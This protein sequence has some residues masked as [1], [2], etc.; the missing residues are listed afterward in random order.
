M[1]Q[2]G[3]I[4]PFA[5]W[6]AVNMPAQVQN[7]VYNPDRL[8]KLAIA[9]KSRDSFAE[10]I[11]ADAY[12][13]PDWILERSHAVLG[14]DEDGNLEVLYLAGAPFEDINR[15]FAGGFGNTMENV[16]ADV[17]PILRAPF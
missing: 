9:T 17:T 1:R 10:D 16:L 14:K 7:L 12:T 5:R 2:G 3:S 11:E 13:M 6:M 4:F 8:S 15:F